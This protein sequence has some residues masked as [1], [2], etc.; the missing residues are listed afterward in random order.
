MSSLSPASDEHCR[1]IVRE[2]ALDAGRARLAAP[3]DGRPLTARGPVPQGRH[4]GDTTHGLGGR[5]VVVVR[6]VGS[7]HP[8]GDGLAAGDPLALAALASVAVPDLVPVRRS[9]AVERSPAARAA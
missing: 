8:Y 2:Q 9:M 3:R 7:E 6:S 4:E 5:L 1:R